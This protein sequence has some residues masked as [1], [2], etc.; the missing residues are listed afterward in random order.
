MSLI[1]NSCSKIIVLSDTPD[2]YGRCAGCGLDICRCCGKA[3][4]H[5]DA[6]ICTRC[7]PNHWGKHARGK[8]NSRCREFSNA[9][10]N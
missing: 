5:K 7:I 9:K 1:C 6:P 10:R 4:H 3:T 2:H 8:S